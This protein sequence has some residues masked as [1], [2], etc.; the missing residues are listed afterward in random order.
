MQKSSFYLFMGKMALAMFRSSRRAYSSLESV[1][2]DSKSKQTSSFWSRKEKNVSSRYII[3]DISQRRCS[4]IPNKQHEY[5]SPERQIINDEKSMGV[6][7]TASTIK[8]KNRSTN[9]KNDDQSVDIISTASTRRM[10]NLKETRTKQEKS[11]ETRASIEKRTNAKPNCKN[12]ILYGSKSKRGSKAD[13]DRRN[14]IN[15]QTPPYTPERRKGCQSV[16]FH[17]SSHSHIIGIQRRE[18]D[19]ISRDE[20]MQNLL[21]FSLRSSKRNYCSNYYDDYATYSHLK[22]PVYESEFDIDDT[23]SDETYS[24]GRFEI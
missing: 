15:K 8:V 10:S 12:W 2:S 5:Y 16:T 22:I 19:Y 13:S 21:S 1:H 9:G 11:I 4:F 14:N 20:K 6:V 17:E 24:E 18:F 3:G 7:S 23:A